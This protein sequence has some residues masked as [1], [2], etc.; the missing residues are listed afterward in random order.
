[1]TMKKAIPFL[2]LLFIIATIACS[3][4]DN[5]GNNNKTFSEKLIGSWALRDRTEIGIEYCE[6][7]TT[8]EFSENNHFT[9]DFYQGDVQEECQSTLADGVWTH[10][11]EQKVKIDFDELS[12]IDTLTI[13]FTNN[14]QRMK[15]QNS[16]TSYTETY[17]KQ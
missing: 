13:Q 12:E 5:P 9:L 16:A 3:K 14:A 7:S 15:L 2:T 8:F 10:L 4:D 17:A 11:G 6:L 1:M